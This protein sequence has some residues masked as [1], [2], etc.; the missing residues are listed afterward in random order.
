MR[1][2]DMPRL[3]T[4]L[5]RAALPFKSKKRSRR[6]VPQTSPTFSARRGHDDWLFEDARPVVGR[7]DVLSRLTASLC[8]LRNC[9]VDV[10]S[11]APIHE[12]RPA[13]YRVE[14]ADYSSL[15]DEGLFDDDLF[16]QPAVPRPVR[17]EP[18]WHERVLF[19]RSPGLMPA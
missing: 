16:D 1:K 9:L 10:A 19:D 4:F 7:T 14:F 15:D 2:S 8:R 6:F 13:C 17:A 5:A 12:E 11:N 3:Q 18:A